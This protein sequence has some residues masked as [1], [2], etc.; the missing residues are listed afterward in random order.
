MSAQNILVIARSLSHRSQ[1]GVGLQLP[2]SQTGLAGPGEYRGA[3]DKSSL[4]IKLPNNPSSPF[5]A[6][7][8]LDPATMSEKYSTLRP[9]FGRTKTIK[10]DDVLTLN[11]T[12]A[13]KSLPPPKLARIGPRHHRRIGK[14]STTTESEEMKLSHIAM[15]TKTKMTKIYPKLAR[16]KFG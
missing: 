14:I 15:W 12:T 7:R 1:V 11:A 6:Q 9:R 3:C 10:T 16:D 4:E 13:A 5:L 2:P 8:E